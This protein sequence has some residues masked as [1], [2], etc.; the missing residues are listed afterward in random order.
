VRGRKVRPGDEVKANDVLTSLAGALSALAARLEAA[1]AANAVVEAM[2]QTNDA[3]A[4]RFLSGALSA[5]AVRLEPA[6]AI[7]RAILAARSIGEELSLPTRLS[8]LATLLQASRLPPCRFLPQE[9]VELLKM[10]TCVGPAREVVLRL[11]GRTYDRHFADLWAFVDWAHEHHP[12]LDLTITTI[13]NRLPIWCCASRRWS[14]CWPRKGWWI[15][16]PSTYSLTP[17]KPKSARVTGLGLSP[18]PGSIPLSRRGCCE[19]PP[20]P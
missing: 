20:R 18:T 13:P 6:E 3:N 2:G 17:T 8:G 16:R 7:G 15:R 9:L 14:R 5:L 1:R 4:L 10:P 11:L 12:E 19:M